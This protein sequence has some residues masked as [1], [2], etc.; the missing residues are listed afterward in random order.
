MQLFQKIRQQR[1][2]SFGLLLITL[3]VGIAIGIITNTGVKAERQVSAVAPDATPLNIP[4]ADPIA[5]DFT[6]LTKRVE[7]SVVYIESDY[8]PKPGKRGVRPKENSED[9]DNGENAEPKDP[10]D[11]F[12]HFFGGPQ[13]RSFRTEGSGT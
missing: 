4:K 11:V 2:L 9:E 3:A 10:S 8:L 6:K 7:P 12:K 13:Q 1:L 5:N